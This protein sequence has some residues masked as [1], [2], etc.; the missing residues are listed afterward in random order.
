MLHQYDLLA[1]LKGH[2]NATEVKMDEL[3][4]WEVL[5]STTIILTFD[6]TIL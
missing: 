5:N 3:T 1:S 6:C 4:F 2:Q